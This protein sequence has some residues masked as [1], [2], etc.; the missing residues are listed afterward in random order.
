MTA[1]LIIWTCLISG[2]HCE[3][4]TVSSMTMLQCNVAWQMEAAKFI[5][6]NPDRKFERYECLP[7]DDEA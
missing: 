5:G 4:H 7:G 3:A 6:E 1:T 2:G